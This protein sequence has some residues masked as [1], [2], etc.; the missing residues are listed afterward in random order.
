MNVA[1][2]DVKSVDVVIGTE[3]ISYVM[4]VLSA[5]K[6]HSS[7]AS[8]ANTKQNIKTTSYVTCVVD[9]KLPAS[10]QYASAAKLKN[11]IHHLLCC[12]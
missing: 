6:K 12:H 5:A 4:S 9:I 10:L 8:I 11:S 2:I 1:C 7:T 3:K